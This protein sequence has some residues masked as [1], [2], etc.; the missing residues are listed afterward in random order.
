V[1]LLVVVGLLTG[2][3]K[4]SE[5]EFAERFEG[6]D[7]VVGVS[8]SCGGLNCSGVVTVATTATA[9]DVED[10]ASELE[11]MLGEEI[12]E[13]TVEVEGQRGLE[14]VVDG[15]DQDLGSLADALV[16]AAVTEEVLSTTLRADDEGTGQS[17]ALVPEL[18]LSRVAEV[19]QQFVD[20]LDA[21]DINVTSGALRIVSTEGAD[22]TAELDLALLVD[23]RY[24]LE[25]ASIVKDELLMRVGQGVDLAEA[26][27]FLRAQPG[28]PDI[29][30]VD[31]RN[32][33]DL[34]LVN[35]DPEFAP[36]A[37][38]M[39]QRL[40]GEPGFQSLHVSQDRLTLAATTLDEAERLDRLLDDEFGERYAGA[41]V[42]WSGGAETAPGQDPDGQDPDGQRVGVGRQPGER[43]LFDLARQLL[44]Q[45]LWATI[46]ISEDSLGNKMV[47]V[48]T[49]EGTGA[50]EAAAALARTDLAELPRR[51][52]V[53]V[54]D[55]RRNI[56]FGSGAEEI[57]PEGHELPAA[58][59]DAFVQGWAEGLAGR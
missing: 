53:R 49:R 50:R 55:L 51:V 57:E 48:S 28:F 24:P 35:V 18:R 22:P 13:G 19:R 16:L 23:R 38:A 29:P 32:R 56:E 5:E 43:H 14:L 54:V 10:V 20:V 41:E 42:T 8:S 45:D 21:P 17:L 12:N 34:S 1:A 4:I 7:G 44:A 47:N 25:E 15:D 27:A 31:V 30:V 2:C 59:K 6:Q 11:G 40:R 46:S 33:D 37:L 39:V 58:D 3:T 9:D 26:T 36:T 52:T